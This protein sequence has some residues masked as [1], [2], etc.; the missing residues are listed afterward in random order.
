MRSLLMVPA[1]L[2]GAAWLQ[3]AAAQ[4][5]TTVAY[6]ADYVLETAE[7]AMRGRIYATPGMERREDLTPDGGTMVSIRREDKNLLWMLIPSERMYMEIK[8]GEMAAGS[9][10]TPSPEEYQTEMTTE[11]RE[12][13]AGVMTTKSKVIMTSADGSKMGGFW[14]TTDEGVLIKM[15]VLS[16]AAGE[17]I[18]MKRELTN[19]QIAPQPAD[20]F[21]I[22]SGYV[23]M[24]AA[25]GGGLLGLGRR[26]NTDEAQSGEGENEPAED[27]QKK[28]RIGIG[29]A[30]RGVLGGR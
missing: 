7:G 3:T 28:R 26:G 18:R 5:E 2:I 15:D 19:V 8:T 20:L 11:G 17:K 13:V 6:S 12:E 29:G 27:D 4:G 10:R 14:W 21:E 30:L 22:P 1:V 24:S 9:E 25:I 23:S 16:I